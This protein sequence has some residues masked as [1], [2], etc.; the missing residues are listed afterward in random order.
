MKEKNLFKVLF[1]CLIL[2]FLFCGCVEIC[3]ENSECNIYNPDG[4]DIDIV[5]EEPSSQQ[6]TPII[7]NYNQYFAEKVVETAEKYLKYSR[8]DFKPVAANHGFSIS[9]D[10]TT[11]KCTSWCAIFVS[12]VVEEANQGLNWMNYKSGSVSEF[13]YQMKADYRFFHTPYWYNYN[14]KHKY[15]PAGFGAPHAG[16]IVFFAAKTCGY[17]GDGQMPSK[18]ENC[19]R[20]IGIVTGSDE[21]YLYYI[22]GNNN[23]CIHD[24]VRKNGVCTGKNEL[25]DPYIIGYGR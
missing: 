25:N 1:L 9:C 21:K 15:N 8:E 12:S 16:D 17:K 10:P 23:S 20:H 6:E 18:T 13:M 22:H 3:D 4:D 19:F 11:N 7:P 5:I 14:G 2:L 24:G